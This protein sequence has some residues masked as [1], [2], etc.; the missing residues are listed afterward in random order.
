[1]PPLTAKFALVDYPVSQARSDCCQDKITIF[2][3][4]KM[5]QTGPMP[6]M[7]PVHPIQPLDNWNASPMDTP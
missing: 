3:S 7:D 4:Q 5:P 2:R 6:A 1:M